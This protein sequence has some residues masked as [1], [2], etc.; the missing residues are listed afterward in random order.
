MTKKETQWA[1]K[2]KRF[3]VKCI[4]NALK[5]S[6]LN[7]HLGMQL[8]LSNWQTNFVNYIDMNTPGPNVS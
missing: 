3:T 6:K 4:K 7:I 1:S 2:K 5:I 8:F